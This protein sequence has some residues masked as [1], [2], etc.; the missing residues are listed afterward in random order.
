MLRNTGRGPCTNVVFK[1]RMPAGVVLMAGS[2][3]VEVPVIPPGHAH[4]HEIAVQ[5]RRPGTFPLTSTNF[6]YRNGFDVPVRVTDFRAD[7]VA[8]SAPAPVLIPQPTGRLRVWCD[9]PE[10]DLDAWDELTIMMSNDTGV[11]LHD[12]TVALR[13]PVVSD[14]RRRGV[15]VLKEGVTARFTLPVRATERGRHVPVVVTTR[16]GHLDPYGTI[17]TVTQENVVDVAVR[18]AASSQPTAPVTQPAAQ[19]AP[20]P[21]AVEQT[22]LYLAASPQDLPRLRSDL[23]MRKVRE[24]LRLGKQQHRFRIDDC[25]A[26]RFDD[27]SQALKDYEPQVV[28]FSGHGDREGYLYLENDLGDGDLISPEGLAE[29]FRLHTPTLRCVIVNACHSVRL[30]EAVSQHIDY[31][32]G[33]RSEILDEASIGF[34]TGF[35]EGLFAGWTVPKAFA[36][37]C[38]HI[39][40]RRALEG[41]HR[42]PLLYSRG[43]EPQ[44]C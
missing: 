30:A 23:E 41:Q 10:L 13:G 42:T 24:R 40:A 12:V 20:Q 32:I 39:Q 21:A 9:N 14:D 34:S 8:R 38:A 5:A 27:L 33:M 19:P 18:S 26:T 11:A 43:A 44:S 37:G 22:I 6:S 25:T 31:V 1:L 16:Y 28:H 29:L 3:R 2:D 35:Y 15:A 4:T 7:L 17:R 36:N